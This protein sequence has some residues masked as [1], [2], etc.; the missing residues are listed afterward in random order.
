MKIKYLLSGV[1]GFTLGM[2]L[3]YVV[4]ENA[5]G[6]HIILALFIFSALVLDILYITD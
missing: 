4:F 5:D 3:C 1:L 2:L 6:F